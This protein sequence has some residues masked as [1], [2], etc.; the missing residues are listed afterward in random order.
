VKKKA[1]APKK[2]AAPKKK[3]AAPKKKSAS[4]AT[5]R[6]KKASAPERAKRP[7]GTDKNKSRGK[8]NANRTD[9]AD[10]RFLP[11]VD[12]FSG[13]AGFSLMESKS[14][15]MRGLMLNSASFGMSSHGRFILKLTE[16][17]V[18]ELIADGTGKAFS[19]AAGRIMKSWIDVTH[20]KADWVAL[21]KEAYLL[22]LA[23]RSK[24]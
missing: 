16:E 18:A 8:S 24:R 17:R 23:Q 11:V 7:Q 12:S 22:A 2:T 5:A 6:A 9:E 15:G 21:A 14:G 4:K 20:P 3:T 10:P 13:T 19:P 1:P